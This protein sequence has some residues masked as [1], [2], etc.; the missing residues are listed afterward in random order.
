VAEADRRV[1]RAESGERTRLLELL[2][3][4]AIREALYRE[5][6]AWRLREWEAARAVYAPGA[7]VEL[8]FDVEP[9]ADAQLA[10]LAEAM[11]GFATSSLLASNC[12]V[13]L[14]PA[15]DAAMLTALI[16]GAHESPPERGERTRLEAV[17]FTDAW[18]RDAAGEWRVS[19]RKAERVW[20][21]WLEPRRDDRE[22][23][24]RHAV[25]WTR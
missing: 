9:H 25:D 8:G 14:A 23:D 3:K 15:R 4:E 2:A 5:L 12:V 21:A 11:R 18:T 10:R 24:H 22:G 1:G 17:R 6:D 13:E 7:R 16:L 19:A 20:R